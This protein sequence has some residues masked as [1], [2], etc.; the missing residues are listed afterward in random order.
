MTLLPSS[1]LPTHFPGR[2]PRSGRRRPRRRSMHSPRCRRSATCRSP[3]VRVRWF[4]ALRVRRPRGSASSQD[5][6]RTLPRTCQWHHERARAWRTPPIAEALDATWPTELRARPAWALIA[7]Q[8]RLLRDFASTARF[9]RSM[10]RLAWLS[11]RSDDEE[12]R[13]PDQAARPRLAHDHSRHSASRR[14][15][16]LPGLRVLP[17]LR[18][19]TRAKA[20]RATARIESPPNATSNR[21]KSSVV[22]CKFPMVRCD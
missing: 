21:K 12:C 2:R 10:P 22:I 15:G 17:R 18:S 4:A 1:D 8:L 16:W 9:K 13:A 7:V 20:R 19:A 14:P 11:S 5:G 3:S 6:L